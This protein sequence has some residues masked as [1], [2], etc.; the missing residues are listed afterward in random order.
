MGRVRSQFH[1]KGSYSLCLRENRSPRRTD[2]PGNQ[3]LY[4]NGIQ[5]YRNKE[6]ADN[7]SMDTNRTEPTEKHQNQM[8]TKFASEHNGEEQMRENIRLSFD[9]AGEAKV[10]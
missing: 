6:T 2:I 10:D 1:Q 4:L 5:R 3:Y 7:G 9:K 8:I